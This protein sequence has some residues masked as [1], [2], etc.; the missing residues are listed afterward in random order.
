MPITSI[1]AHILLLEALL[2]NPIEGVRP[3]EWKDSG[4]SQ[5]AESGQRAR[6]PK[7]GLGFIETKRVLPA[8][9]DFR[10]FAWDNAC[11]M[12]EFMEHGWVIAL[13]LDCQLAKAQNILDLVAEDFYQA[14][15][16]YRQKL[17]EHTQLTE[18]AQLQSCD[19][20]RCPRCVG[21]KFGR[22]EDGRSVLLLP[23]PTMGN[24]T[25]YSYH[26]ARNFSGFQDVD[27]PVDVKRIDRV[28]QYALMHGNA[29]NYSSEE[30]YFLSDGIQQRL[31]WLGF[32]PEIVV[33]LE[34]APDV[35]KSAVNMCIG[36]SVG[37]L[38]DA[39]NYHTFFAADA[40]MPAT[41]P[42]QMHS[43]WSQAHRSRQTGRLKV[44]GS[45][46]TIDADH[47]PMGT[48]RLDIN[49]DQLVKS[50]LHPKKL[51]PN[52]YA[53]MT[54]P[55]GGV[56]GITEKSLR[57]L[58]NYTMTSEEFQ[59]PAG[60]VMCSSA[61]RDRNCTLETP[62]PLSL[63][64]ASDVSTYSGVDFSGLL[65]RMFPSPSNWHQRQ[66]C[67]LGLARDDLYFPRHHK[68][69]TVAYCT[70]GTFPSWGLIFGTEFGSF[71]SMADIGVNATQLNFSIEVDSDGLLVDD[72]DTVA[73]V[74]VRNE[75]KTDLNFKVS[76]QNT[77]ITVEPSFGHISKHQTH[78]VTFRVAEGYQSWLRQEKEIHWDLHGEDYDPDVLS[79]TVFIEPDPNM[80]R[81][82]C[83]RS[84]GK[85]RVMLTAKKQLTVVGYIVAHYGKL[86]LYLLVA[87][88]V[89]LLLRFLRRIIAEVTRRKV[90]EAS[91]LKRARESV[92]QLSFPMVLVQASTFRSWK[93]LVAHEDA[94][95]R[96][97]LT[98][99]YTQQEVTDFFATKFIIFMSHQ[100]TGFSEPDPAQPSDGEHVQYNAMVVSIDSVMLRNGLSKDDEDRVFIWVDYCSI[101]QRHRG[102][103]TLAIH[104]LTLYAAHVH[105]FIAVA[106]SI[107]HADHFDETGKPVLCNKASYQERAWCRA[108][109]LSHL[110]ARGRQNMFL[111]ENDKLIPLADDWLDLAI[112]VFA[113]EMTC[114][115]LQH[116]TVD[117]C[118]KQLLA[119]P[120]LGLWAQ[121]CEKCTDDHCDTGVRKQQGEDE[122]AYLDRL[123]KAHELREELKQIKGKIDSE[124]RTVF[125]STFVF[126]K[127][128]CCDRQ[129]TL[130][131]HLIYKVRTDGSQQGLQAEPDESS[132]DC[133]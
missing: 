78:V 20:E 115:R 15:V 75:G 45:K 127:K 50:F 98:W 26:G 91:T 96:Q 65:S 34:P 37:T 41:R 70:F 17:I 58:Y 80:P 108:E 62:V 11:S 100:W 54:D 25:A 125:P 19:M 113:G 64:N 53:L 81:S 128:G 122:H 1:A 101:P 73:H 112:M 131:G 132:D 72:A 85:V 43:F 116:A 90:E 29:I 59:N 56:I 9:D 86:A 93:Q 57:I 88:A 69:H 30:F 109:Q 47:K 119:V 46:T 111:A 97:Q 130:F 51:A 95:H 21:Q 27:T 42:A 82:S 12:D 107:P 79:H 74:E 71:D 83:Y 99:L 10:D 18:F 4:R 77:F 87:L 33:S 6:G 104:S 61:T 35:N 8:C 129:K 110:L 40:E 68:N 36:P 121:L 94:Q 48:V 16:R 13:S 32:D 118:D 76:T 89:V 24:Q 120:M 2:L 5:D 31:R 39:E 38:I 44:T 3:V 23:T 92:N 133:M 7:S 106:P 114:C 126:R 105:A 60:L 22:T 124:L 117:T 123:E 28:L 63:S 84:Y 66:N 52:V 102:L 67:S 55:F 103:Q 14:D 49:V